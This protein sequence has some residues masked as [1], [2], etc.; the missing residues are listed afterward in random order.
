MKAQ[1]QALIEAP[2]AMSAGRIV[3]EVVR[4]EIGGCIRDEREVELLYNVRDFVT[5]YFTHIT[6]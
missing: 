1:L 3:F 2:Q 4:P 5:S 6:A